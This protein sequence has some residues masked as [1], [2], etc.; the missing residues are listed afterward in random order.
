MVSFVCCYNCC[1]SL[2]H[3]GVT[4]ELLAVARNGLG[5]VYYH[6]SFFFCTISG[7][8]LYIIAWVVTLVL[9]FMSL[10]DLPPGAYK[11]IHW[12]TFIPHV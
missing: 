2:Y 10:R 6:C 9:A 8:I 11:T 5:E 7:A 3:F 4:F 1:P 12:T